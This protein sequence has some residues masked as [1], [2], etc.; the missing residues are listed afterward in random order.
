M[1]R[2]SAWLC[3]WQVTLCGAR[4][5]ALVLGGIVDFVIAAAL[6][7]S[8]LAYGVAYR[9]RRADRP[10]WP[11]L[12]MIALLAATAGWVVA[13]PGWWS[14]CSA[15]VVALAC[16]VAFPVAYRPTRPGVSETGATI[17]LTLV[18][19]LAVVAAS[20]PD[21][22]VT[23]GANAALPEPRPVGTAPP[24][25]PEDHVDAALANTLDS[26]QN[27]ASAERTE[28][29]EYAVA[30]GVLQGS[31]VDPADAV[32]WQLF[33]AIAVDPALRNS[34]TRLNMYGVNSL[35]GAYS[36]AYVEPT[37]D[38]G[39]QWAVGLNYD[40]IVDS[41]ETA[42][43]MIHEYWHLETLHD[44]Q[45]ITAGEQPHDGYD[46]PTFTI[47]EGCAMED[48]IL[49]PWYQT[50]WLGNGLTHDPELSTEQVDQRY[51][52]HKGLFV[53][54]YAATNPIEDYAETFAYWVLDDPIPDAKREFLES[55]P[56]LV[57][58]KRQIRSNIVANAAG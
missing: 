1:C 28:S 38:D 36:S 17:G 48:S 49:W 55:T 56:D 10:R 4:P 37:D 29:T 15:V 8:A 46:C 9:L 43:T 22:L 44:D 24:P 14:W 13:A 33:S 6:V 11:T 50:H 54:D 47:A 32:L 57:T 42:V 21:R 58:K 52:T 18:V 16:A 20:S 39:A 41:Q 40:A 3:G 19:I 30:Q 26:Y 2:L 53:N 34:V 27:I 12:L 31:D 5:Q 45:L 35:D 25:V 23:A 7:A 51:L